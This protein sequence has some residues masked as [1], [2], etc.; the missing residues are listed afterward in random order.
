MLHFTE[1]CGE[2]FVKAV[3]NIENKEPRKLFPSHF[4]GSG[5]L[6]DYDVISLVFFLFMGWETG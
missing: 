4:R 2:D 3:S 6:V 1:I 5:T